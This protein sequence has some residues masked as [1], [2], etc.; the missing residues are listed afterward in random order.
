MSKDQA[1]AISKIANNVVIA[2]AITITKCDDLESLVLPG[3]AILAEHIH[4]NS[5]RNP[6]KNST[7]DYHLYAFLAEKDVSTI[8]ET[9]L[10]RL[11][12]TTLGAPIPVDMAAIDQSILP[13]LPWRGMVVAERLSL[14]NCGATL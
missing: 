13:F 14:S 3:A 8:C 4:D 2:Y 11:G 7:Y 9:L 5:C 1:Q 12:Y 10:Q 6:V